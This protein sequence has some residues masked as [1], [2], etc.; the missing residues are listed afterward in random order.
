[1]VLTAAAIIV[2]AASLFFI[3]PLFTRNVDPAL[4]P[5]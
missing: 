5:L 4:L 3:P 2:L 1:M